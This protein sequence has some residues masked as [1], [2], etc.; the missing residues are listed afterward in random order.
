[1]DS[2]KFFV[3]PGSRTGGQLHRP[4]AARSGG[5]GA[6]RAVSVSLGRIFGAQSA[7]YY[8]LLGTT[9]FLLVFG[10]I[11]VL[12]SSSVSSYLQS[13][14]FFSQFL[15][16]GL[17][18][19]IGVPL[20]LIAARMPSLFWKRWAGVATL[21]AIALQ[22]LVVATPLGVT[23]GGNQNWLGV[24][25]FT[26]QPSEITKVALAIWLG[27]MLALR[28][29]RLGDL[30]SVALPIAPVAGVA[31]ALVL[32]GGDL[33]TSAILVM[34]VLGALFFAG[35][36]LRILA[37]PVAVIAVVTPL[38]LSGSRNERITVWLSGCTS[39]TD[40]TGYCWQTLHGWWALAAGGVFG[41]GLGQSREKWS[42]LPAA[43][44]DFIFAIV[45]EELGLVGAVLLL[46]LYV[47]LAV[48]FVRIIRSQSDP[49]ARVTVAVIMVWI[50]GQAL[51]NIAV[52]LG[53]LPVLGVPMP[54]VSAG[55]SS[56][57]TTLVAV[58][59]ALSFAR[60]TTAASDTATAT[61]TGIDTGHRAEEPTRRA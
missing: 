10:L 14:D 34:M 25:A 1:M 58:G 50:V 9:L 27:H 29:N 37:I 6:G 42:W 55:G 46:V 19:F 48:A 43:D 32:I 20:M 41:V 2:S 40:Y 16:Q 5:E 39:L 47:V 15:R 35:V 13:Q 60:N 61:A 11:M 45:G 28:A 51:T 18:A 17:F 30:R 7:N 52:V 24:G 56:L 23:R 33:G 3:R 26:L 12:S 21:G 49:F 59:V 38:L 53:I 31:I 8:L 57:V 36:R 4:G 44:N 54:L 22:L